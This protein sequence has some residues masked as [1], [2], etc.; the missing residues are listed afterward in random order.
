MKNIF[1]VLSSILIF[2]LFLE[3]G[4][5]LYPNK[6]YDKYKYYRK[7]DTI[8]QIGTLQHIPDD[9][10]GYAYAPSQTASRR[11]ACYNNEHIAIN[12]R[13]FRDKEWPSV[14][15]SFSVAAFGD[16]MIVGREVSEHQVVTSVLGELLGARVYNLG[17]NGYA[18]MNAK[19]TYEVFANSLRPNVVL[20]FAYLGND[21]I[22][23]FCPFSNAVNN[24]CGSVVENGEIVFS[25]IKSREKVTTFQ[26]KGYL[27][28]LGKAL[29]N[30]S[31]LV[32][33]AFEAKIT[34]ASLKRT[35]G[36]FRSRIEIMNT[37]ENE[38]WRAAWRVFG[39]VI[40]TFR[41]SVEAK[42]EK[43]VL[44]L[45]PDNKI[46]GPNLRSALLS[47]SGVLGIPH[48]DTKFPSKRAESVAKKLKVDY[49]NLADTFEKYQNRYQ[50]SA[51]YFS[52]RC[53]GH[54]NPLGHFVAA[55][56]IADFLIT[57][58]YVEPSSP[59]DMQNLVSLKKS[60]REILGND[61]FF[62]IYESG[63]YYP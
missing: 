23:N 37:T 25:Q 48:L 56:A 9:I 5:R 28:K 41:Q 2:T 44:V 32:H 62:R 27:W 8:G 42:G 46:Y 55:Q 3:L 57:K 14:P 12:A 17:V 50:L 43:F 47:L 39:E 61:T 21:V 6:F 40:K 33:V 4:L 35:N 29:G 10:R 24:G 26:P 63:T 53:D 22:Q 20:F 54:W 60:P 18:P 30:V 36:L 59:S 11:S 38:D 15:L 1:L 13:G 51:P 52:Y 19:K 45:V 58:G 16:S 34:L 49:I 31:V 7:N